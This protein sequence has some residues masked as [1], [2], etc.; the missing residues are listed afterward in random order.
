[1]AGHPLG[2]IAATTKF[3]PPLPIDA[4]LWQAVASFL[5]LSP[6]HARLVELILRGLND[7]EMAD[8]M[9]I[10]KSTLRTYFDRIAVRT[11]AR[12][13]TAI[14]RK[15]LSVSH[16]VERSRPCPHQC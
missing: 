9:G 8:A 10:H 11:G 7:K 4:D 14:L 2:K 5:K 13:R 1:M 12:G 15:V 3:L 16:Q 6:Q